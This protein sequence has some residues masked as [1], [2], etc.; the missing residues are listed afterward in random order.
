MDSIKLGWIPTKIKKKVPTLQ[1]I[2]SFEQVILCEKLY[3]IQLPILF[4]DQL[5]N[6]LELYSTLFEK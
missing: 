6:Y 3:K 1:C 2:S 4:L 5:Y